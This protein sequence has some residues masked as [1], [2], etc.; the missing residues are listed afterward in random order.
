M[1]ATQ[2]E[3]HKALQRSF[4]EEVW[5]NGDIEKCSACLISVAASCQAEK[6]FLANAIVGP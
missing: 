6:R 3:S 5:S 1:T 4:L 2:D